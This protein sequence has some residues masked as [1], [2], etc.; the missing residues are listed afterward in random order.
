MRIIYNYFV[1]SIVL[2]C[3][4]L[5]PQLIYANTSATDI[6]ALRNYIEVTWQNLMRTTEDCKSLIDP[7]THQN[8]I[9]YIPA[10]LKKT[11]ALQQI[12]KNCSVIIKQL[13]NV[14]N[15]IG[16]V[17]VKQIY[18]SGILYLPKPYVVPGGMFNEMYGWDS[19]FIMLGLIENRKIELAK[20]MVENFFFEIDY[21][22][23][24][25]NA[26]RS[27]YLSRSQPPFLT[28]MIRLVYQETKDLPWLK[29][30]YDYAVRDYA[31]WNK[32]PHIAGDTELARYY[33]F[34]YGP[35]PELDDTAQNY[36][37]KILQ[38]YLRLPKKYQ[39][40]LSKV[41]NKFP[42]APKLQNKTL[43]HDFYL[44]DRA[45]RESGFDTSH[46]F[47]LFSAATTDYA[48]VELNSLLYKAEGDLA[49][50]CAQLHLNSEQNFW[51]QK[52]AKRLALINKYFWNEKA[53]MYFDYNFKRNKQSRYKYATTFYPLWAQA[54]SINQAKRVHQ[55]LHLFERRGGLVTSPYVTGAQ[56]D[57]PYGWAPIQ[58]I[59][60]AA[61]QQ[62]GYKNSAERLARK[63]INVVLKNYKKD[64]TIREKYDMVLESSQTN[65][66]IGYKIN[67]AGFGWTNGV[68]LYLLNNYPSQIMSSERI[69]S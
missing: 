24:I 36:Y 46:R 55:K 62:Y 7:K 10:N 59:A 16:D 31:L 13:P 27:Y 3:S 51:Q 4:L 17:D 25:L 42:L 38:F 6:V 61:L 9:L 54:A 15:T 44:G 58:Y 18:P 52:A 33:D 29:K 5:I 12:Q 67:V 69:I 68:I 22:G 2:F 39:R 43:S 11:D 14:I 30:A 48:P 37:K 49:F 8:Y 64:K 23:G 50:M 21:Y 35:V 60:I 45:M 34:S 63:Y 65:V 28:S 32:A 20:N 19:Y 53:G 1:L 40:F 47:G 56:W 57:A 26:N 66:A 41:S